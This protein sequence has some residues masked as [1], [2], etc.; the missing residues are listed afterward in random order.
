LKVLPNAF[1]TTALRWRKTKKMPTVITI[2][3]TLATGHYMIKV[4]AAAHIT[5]LARRRQATEMT[6]SSSKLKET[7]EES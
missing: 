2:R 6:L 4:C 7:L 1:A 5:S 3:I